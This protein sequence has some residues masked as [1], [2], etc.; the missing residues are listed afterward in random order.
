MKNNMTLK[1]LNE[2]AKENGISEDTKLFVFGDAR[3]LAV[4]EICT[5]SPA[6]DA[7]YTDIYFRIEKETN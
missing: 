4:T 7:L 2:F 6:K 1:D 5:E 3:L